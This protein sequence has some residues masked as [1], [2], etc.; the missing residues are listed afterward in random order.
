MAVAMAPKIGGEAFA[1][2]GEREEVGPGADGFGKVI[3]CWLCGLRGI[4][5][6]ELS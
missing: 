2:V 5:V 3:F 4:S 6:Y 1:V